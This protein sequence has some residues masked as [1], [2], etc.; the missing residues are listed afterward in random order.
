MVLTASID[1]SAGNVA[2]SDSETVALTV[3]AGS[4]DAGTSSIGA[5]RTSGVTADGTDASTLTI[6]VQDAAGNELSGEEVFFSITSGEWV[7]E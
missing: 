4:A 2:A 6:T 3:S 7:A 1:A 5:D